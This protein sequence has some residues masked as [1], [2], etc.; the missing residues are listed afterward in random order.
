MTRWN[1]S[2]SIRETPLERVPD[3]RPEEKKALSGKFEKKVLG[4]KV[5]GRKVVDRDTERKHERRHLE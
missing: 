4:M 2:E 3:M 5:E 1:G